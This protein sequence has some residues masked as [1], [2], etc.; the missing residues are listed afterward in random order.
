MISP[1]TLT[2]RK[3]L[4]NPKAAIA[5]SDEEFDI[6]PTAEVITIHDDSNDKAIQ[7]LTAPAAL[8]GKST[9]APNGMILISSRWL[10]PTALQEELQ[11]RVKSALHSTY[12]I[13]STQAVANCHH[14]EKP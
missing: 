9:L 1:L 6:Y 5:F 12:A 4:R 13:A 8:K 3:S 14:Q 7:P 11:S 2:H 10:N